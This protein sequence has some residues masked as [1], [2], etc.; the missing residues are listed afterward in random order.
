MGQSELPLHPGKNWKGC[1][2]L[3]VDQ[4]AVVGSSSFPVFFQYATY[5]QYLWH[6]L[7]YSGKAQLQECASP[8]LNL[9]PESGG[10]NCQRI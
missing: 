6:H 2:L 10:I 8:H 9:F 7:D 3:D 1:G 5:L 4:Q